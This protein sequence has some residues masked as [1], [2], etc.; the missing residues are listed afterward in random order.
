MKAEH[1]KELQTNALADRMGRFIRRVKQRPSRGRV[2]TVLLVLLVLGAGAFYLWRR[3]A[4]KEQDA[5]LWEQF[6][7]GDAILGRTQEGRPVYN[8]DDLLARHPK[9]PQGRATRVQVAWYFLYETGIKRLLEPPGLRGQ[10]E[11]ALQMIERAKKEYDKLLPEV[12]DDPVLAPEVKYAL[13]VIEETLVV[14]EV[15]TTDPKAQLDKAANLYKAVAE[16]YEGAGSALAKRA[17]QRY[18]ELTTPAQRQEIE[19][20]YTELRKEMQEARQNPFHQL[21]P[22][23]REKLLKRG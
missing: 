22:E 3:S 11:S 15:K 1:R 20:F 23:W 19:K 18:Q 10:Q 12:K 17:R 5:K 13:A 7:R 14:D 8:Y 4:G 6:G 21:P 2:L 9:T 16:D